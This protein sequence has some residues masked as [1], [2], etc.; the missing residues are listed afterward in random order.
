MK[1]GYVCVGGGGIAVEL[2]GRI[3]SS[4]IGDHCAA[5]APSTN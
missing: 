3:R 4:A 5:M 1:K 2:G